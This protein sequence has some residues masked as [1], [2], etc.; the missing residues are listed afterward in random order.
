MFEKIDKILY[1]NSTDLLPQFKECPL[2][3]VNF[4]KM[5]MNVIK[6]IKD[7]TIIIFVEDRIGEEFRSETKLMKHS[8]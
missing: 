1:L 7:V 5:K 8:D 4:A 6:R 3:N 2:R